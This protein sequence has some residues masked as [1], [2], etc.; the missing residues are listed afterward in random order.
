[1]GGAITADGTAANIV[2]RYSSSCGGRTICDRSR[3]FRRAMRRASSDSHLGLS[4]AT[5]SPSEMPVRATFPWRSAGCTAPVRP[6]A[7]PAR[8]CH[9]AQKY[10]GICAVSVSREHSRPSSLLAR[11]HLPRPAVLASTHAEPRRWTTCRDAVGRSQR[12]CRQRRSTARAR[13]AAPSDAAADAAFLLFLTRRVPKYCGL[14][15]GRAA[16]PLR[17]PIPRR[18]P[19]PPFYPPPGQPL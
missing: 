2:S 10:P 5:H 14:F 13:L 18:K 8:G 15:E 9:R 6:C 12:C 1:M 16:A 3:K 4:C 11:L 19:R 7:A 17:G